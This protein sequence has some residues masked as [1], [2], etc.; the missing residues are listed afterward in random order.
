M[1]KQNHRQIPPGHL[2]RYSVG[3]FI[4]FIL[5]FDVGHEKNQHKR[6]VFDGVG[7]KFSRVGIR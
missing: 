3:G 5:C 2:G 4:Y 1:R 6:S 7:W